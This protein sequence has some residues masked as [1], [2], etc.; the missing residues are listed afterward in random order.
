MPTT[1]Q[2]FRA[3]LDLLGTALDR[4]QRN[5]GG[6]AFDGQAVVGGGMI[7]DGRFLL[8]GPVSY[9]A[10]ADGADA[11]VTGGDVEQPGGDLRI[12]RFSKRHRCDR[13]RR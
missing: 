6:V 1:K 2:F 5:I 12:A 3:Q 7:R 8:L 4:L 9:F 11:G 13:D 10:S